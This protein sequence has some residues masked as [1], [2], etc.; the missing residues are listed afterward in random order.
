MK[1]K[2]IN[3]DSMKNEILTVYESKDDSFFIQKKGEGFSMELSSQDMN[4]KAKMIMFYCQNID[5]L[6][7]KYGER[8]ILLTMVDNISLMLNFRNISIVISSN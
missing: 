3:K 8:E 6:L 5:E 2:E 7:E 4:E 1:I